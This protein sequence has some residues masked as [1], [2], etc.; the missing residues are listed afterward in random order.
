MKQYKKMLRHILANGAIKGDRTGTGTISTFGY[1]MRFDLQ[2]G[3]PILTTKKIH[4]KS[5]VYELL[6]LISGNT[7]VKWLQERGVKIWDEWANADGDLGPVYGHS[8]RH[9]MGSYKS[10]DGKHYVYG[11]SRAGDSKMNL[12]EGKDQLAE[13]IEKIK[14]KPDDRRLIVSAWNPL[15]L[16][17]Q[18]LPPCHSFFQFYV[19]NGKL[20]CHMYQRSA[21][22]FLGVPFNIA[23][24]ALLTHLVAIITG[25]EVGEFVHSFGD[26]HIYKN[27]EA[28]IREQLTRHT[29]KLPKLRVVWPI[30]KAP[31]TIDE[32]VNYK[33]DQFMLL[34]Y[35]P[36]PAIKAEVSV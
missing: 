2:K 9:F 26:L 23:S 20:S 14:T 12:F 24:Y 27:H 31:K 33:D 7:N 6:W 21:D 8:W 17:D 35:E 11:K 32:F 18:G 16:E 15:E 13:V 19:S 34:G 30:N 28:Q 29:R 36:H 1:Q 22:A 5:V 25:L 3:F 10:K 4:W